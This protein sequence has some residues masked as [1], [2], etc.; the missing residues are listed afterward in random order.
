MILLFY[1]KLNY[2]YHLIYVI[3]SVGG[4]MVF[5][6]LLLIVI[7]LIS[8]K[9]N[10]KDLNFNY[11]DRS[12]TTIING[13]FVVIVFFS[14]FLSYNTNLNIY[15]KSLNF[16][17]IKLGQLIVATFLFYSG[18]GIYE[19][20]KKNKEQ[21]IDSFFKKRFIPTFLN[22]WVAILLFLLLNLVLKRTYSIK[23]ILL[24]FIG[25]ESIGNSNWYMFA[26]FYLYLSVL[27]SF[28][29]FKGEDKYNLIIITILTFIYVYYIN[30]YRF[31]H[32]CTTILCFVGGMWYSF[33][34][35]KIDAFVMRNF[36][37]YIGTIIISG[38]LLL[39]FY[40]ERS[41]I[42]IHNLLSITFVFMINL[43]NMKVTSNSKILLFLGKNVFWIYILQRISMIIF[44]NRLNIYL[45]FIICLSITLVL[46]IILKNITSKLWNKLLK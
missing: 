9:I 40:H 27:F 11:I 18:F 44:Q 2:Y 30:I 45:Y 28:K 25:W 37:S 1:S 41:N 3:I 31:P 17:I 23:N 33:F 19:K 34:K 39:I 15:D 43:F 24:S 35:D 8:I 46:A 20:I 26:I 16:I 7:Y 5:I 22:F 13:I 38:L 36:K 32:W 42:Y 29:L 21:Y 6:F 10:F 4:S 12:N 14:H